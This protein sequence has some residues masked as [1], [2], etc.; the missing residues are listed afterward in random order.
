MTSRATRREFLK[1]TSIASAGILAAGQALDLLDTKTADAK[2]PNVNDDSLPIVDTHQHLWDLTKFDLPWTKGGD[3]ASL[4]R[5]FVS[6]DYMAAIKGSNVVKS[7]YM[8]VDVTPSQQSKEAD[9]VIDICEKG[10]TPMVA[11]VISGRPNSAEFKDYA[12]KYSKNKYIKGIRQ[13]LHVDETP[14][15]YCIETAFVK[16][17]KLLG[18]L[19][20]S[21]DLCMRAGELLD[22]VKLVDQCPKTRFILD[23]CGNLSVQNTD[24]ALRAKWQKGMQELAARPNVVC[25]ISG[26]IA[27]AKKDWKPD[28]LAPNVKFSMDTFGPDRVMFAGD[29]PVCTLTATYAQWVSALKTITKDVNP[30]NRKKLFHD[31]AVKYYGLS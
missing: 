30:A 27:S 22:A 19:G 6:A 14:A 16:G 4:A 21:F 20:L 26:I 23:H 25:K 3:A 7:V 11:A 9:Y 29:W 2:G 12:T 5:S 15:G 8:E 31:N 13:V 10:E 17:I 18:D 1:Q 28:D 24:D